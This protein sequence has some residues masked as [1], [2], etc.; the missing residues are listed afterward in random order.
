MFGNRSMMN[1][2]GLWVMSS[3]TQSAPLFFI[4]LSMA[5]A[6]TSRGASDFS[7]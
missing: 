3:S 1:R 4:S 7:G 2:A 6:T 5:R